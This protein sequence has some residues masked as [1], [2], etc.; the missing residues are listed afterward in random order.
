MKTF[1]SLLCIALTFLLFVNMTFGQQAPIT[2]LQYSNTNMIT[3]TNSTAKSNDANFAIQAVVTVNTPAAIAFTC[4]TTDICTTATAHGFTTGLKTQVSTTTTL[5]TG[6]SGSTDYFPIVLSS[7]TFS[8]ATSLANAQA[9]T[10]IDITG[11]GSGTHTITPT[12]I[13]GASVKLQGSIDCTNFTDIAN[14]STNVTA[15][16]NLLW[17]LA[18]QHYRCVRASSTLTAGMMKAD[19]YY[20]PAPR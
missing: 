14:T 20:S 8:L 9:G 17:S 3:T 16:V 5:P 6:L 12:S 18:D 7:T 11:A 2:Q 15:T 19:I 10:V 13:A 4:A 1:R